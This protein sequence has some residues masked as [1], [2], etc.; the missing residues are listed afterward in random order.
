MEVLGIERSVEGDQVQSTGEDDSDEDGS[1]DD[2]SED[3]DDL[4]IIV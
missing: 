2:G 4:V 3:E 1:D